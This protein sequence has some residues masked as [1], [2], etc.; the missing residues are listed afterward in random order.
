M[1]VLTEFDNGW[2]FVSYGEGKNG[3]VDGSYLVLHEEP[4]VN[5]G[6]E[7]EASVT[8][9]DSVGHFFRPVGD[10]KVYFGGID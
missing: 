1:T 5:E 3:Y 2:R 4:E 7:A 10:F 8:I 6:D 9:V